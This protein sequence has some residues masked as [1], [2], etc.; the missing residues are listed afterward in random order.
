MKTD[1]IT[2]DYF[3]NIDYSY[4]DDLIM[5]TPGETILIVVKVIINRGSPLDVYNL[6]INITN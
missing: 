6:A 4:D 3:S 1:K 5:V 2:V